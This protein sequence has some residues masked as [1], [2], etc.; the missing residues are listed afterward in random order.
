LAWATAAPTKLVHSDT[1]TLWLFAPLEAKAGVP[2]PMRL[3]LENTRLDWIEVELAGRAPRPAKRNRCASA[4]RMI[5][6]YFA[7]K[8]CERNELIAQMPVALIR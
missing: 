5:L 1:I 3:E 2:V 4:G 6:S 8:G 7:K